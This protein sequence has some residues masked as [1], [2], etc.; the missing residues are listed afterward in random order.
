LLDHVIN[1]ACYANL[2][3]YDYILN[4]TA[5]FTKEELTK[6][7]RWLRYGHWNRVPHLLASIELFDWVL[8]TLDFS[9]KDLTRPLES[10]AHEWHHYDKVI[11][12][13]V[14]SDKHRGDS[15]AFSS[16]AVLV[17]NSPFGRSV[18]QHWYEVAMGLC[19]AGNFPTNKK[20]YH[21]VDSD[22]PGL[23]YGLTKA[24]MEF[25]PQHVDV[26]CCYRC[27]GL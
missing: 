15:F 16:F 14:P 25:Y 20:V 3:G 9:F 27:F 4:T 7:R 5:G 13:L 19:P 11:N 26:G 23:W 21:W 22:Q 10:F 6:D 8:Y 24:Y 1:R 18:L 17:R 12:V 2:W